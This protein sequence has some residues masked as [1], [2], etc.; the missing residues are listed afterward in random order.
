MKRHQGFTLIELLI[1][2]AVIGIVGTAIM[3]L[4]IKNTRVHTSQTMV[5]QTQQNL[6]AALDFLTQQIRMA[7][8]SNPT[9][10]SGGSVN[11]GI[12]TATE[13]RFQF[14]ADLNENGS[15]GDA[16]EDIDIRLS[17]GD[18]GNDD[19]VAD[20]NSATLS[21]QFNGAGGYQPVTEN[22]HAISFAY[23]I[24]A[25]ANGEIDTYTAGSDDIILWAIPDPSGGGNWMR[26]DTNGDGDID[27]TDDTDNNGTLDLS[28]TGESFDKSDIMA[29]RITLLGTTGINDQKFTNTSTYTVG[30]HVLNPEDSIKRRMLTTH[31]LCRNL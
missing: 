1:V 3:T 15:L 16:Q 22:I 7:G 29:V 4:Y 9:K 10:P 2:T 28:D 25:N 12:S 20:S 11:A 26:L 27:A 24:D 30:R 13:S 23:G 6:R 18:D 21:I 8:Y 17:P 31:I 14:T 5:V 19:G